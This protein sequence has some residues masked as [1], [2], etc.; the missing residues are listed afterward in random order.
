MPLASNSVMVHNEHH[1]MSMLVVF[2]QVCEITMH[3]HR[4]ITMITVRSPCA[5][6]VLSMPI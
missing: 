3:D 4:E 2:L 6:T 1:T 5:R